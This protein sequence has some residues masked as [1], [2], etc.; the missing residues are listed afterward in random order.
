MGPH[1]RMLNGAHYSLKQT[2]IIIIVIIV[3]KIKHEYNSLNHDDN[4]YG[5]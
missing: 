4:E 5:G 3:K 2:L 1:T